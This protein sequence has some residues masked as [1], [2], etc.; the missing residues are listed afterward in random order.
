MRRTIIIVV[1]VL[2]LLAAGFFFVRQRQLTAQETAVEILREATVENGRITATVNATG[3]I[4]PEALVTLTFRSTGTI[5]QVNAERGQSVQAGDVLATLDTEELQLSVQQAEDALRIQEL[6]RQQRLNNELS[7]A[8]MASAQADIDAA[9]AQLE[10][11]QANQAAAE[12]GVLQAQAQ[13][14]QL[15]AGATAGQIAAAESQVATAQLQYKN[16]EDAHNRTLECFSFTL[17]TG[18]KEEKCPGLGEPEEQAR[19]NLENAYAALNAAEAQLADVKAPP[20]AA[21]IQAVDAAIASAE[22]NVL[23]AKGNVAA[24][25]ANL[26]R[27]QAALARMQEPPTDDEL[28]IL[29]A[30]IASAQTNLAVAQLRLEQSMIV[31]PIDGTVANVLINAGE[32]ASPGAP[33]ISVVNE[34]AFHINVNVDEIDIDQISIGQNVE[35]TLDALQDAVLTGTIAEI[36]PTSASA[37]GVVT[38]LVT[39]NIVADEGVTLRPGM[40]ANASIVVQEI[41][42]VLIVPN[43]A[44]RLDRETGNAYVLQ[45]LADGTTAEVVVETGLRNEQFSEVLSGLQ[46]GDVVVVTTEREAFSF[47]GN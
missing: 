11:A 1:V 22:A 7:P 25:E 37:G 42:N 40:S 46:A 26:S 5:R 44:V 43:W 35:V 27:A 23:A 38:Y 28:A 8:A 47:F 6:T 34:D 16:A 2:I 39:I 32:Q 9:M 20:R 18:E 17:P 4:E 30:Q 3:S 31:A 14:A 36:S 15:L 45:K 24:A 33:A 10:V 19:A 29:D 41:D 21:D 12:A 13:K